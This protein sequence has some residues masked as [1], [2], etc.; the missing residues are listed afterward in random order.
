MAASLQIW[1]GFIY[2]ELVCVFQVAVGGK[3]Y[4]VFIVYIFLVKF[5]IAFILWHSALS[6]WRDSID[7]LSHRF[8]YFRLELRI[9]TGEIV[10]DI[11]L[12]KR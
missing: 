5:S 2:R 8:Y 1:N 12:S 10:M 9:I 6:G 7:L 3:G 4:R 11:A